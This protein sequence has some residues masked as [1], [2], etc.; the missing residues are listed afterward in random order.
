MGSTPRALHVP[1]KMTVGLQKAHLRLRAP[2][3]PLRGL[4]V[5]RTAAGTNGYA[6]LR[7]SRPLYRI[8]PVLHA[9]S[10]HR[11]NGLLYNHLNL[12]A[13]VL[14]RAGDI[15]AERLPADGTTPLPIHS[16]SCYHQPQDLQP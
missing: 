2:R 4:L 5:S 11:G 9:L 8:Y 14:E 6:A 15:F 13:H 10:Q 3:T 16:G 1:G 7:L 12:K